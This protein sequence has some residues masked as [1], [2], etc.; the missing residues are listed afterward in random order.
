MSLGQAREQAAEI[1]ERIGIVG[2]ITVTRFFG[3]AGLSIDGVQ[4]AFVMKGSLYLRVDDASRPHFE[5]HRSEPFR[6]HTG[7]RSVTVASYYEVPSEVIDNRDALADWALRARDAALS[8]RR[9]RTSSNTYNTN[10]V[11]KGHR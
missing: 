7:A 8:G 2:P 9:Q 10:D 5:R 3:G 6:Y 11:T 1:A 4:F